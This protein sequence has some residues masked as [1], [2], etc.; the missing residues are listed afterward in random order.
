MAM[1]TGASEERRWR[2]ITA[3]FGQVERELEAGL[4]RHYGLGLSE[5]RALAELAGAAAGELRM[6]ELADALG[7]NQSSVSRLI[8]R[9]DAAG[10]TRREMCPD[11]RRGVYTAITERGRDRWRD[12]EPSYAQMLTRA[13]DHAAT[14]RDLDAVIHALRA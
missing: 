10:L 1:S 12:A 2:L 3:L 13:L 6:Q 14:N 7:L 9:L 5:Y 11:D 4:L 8:G